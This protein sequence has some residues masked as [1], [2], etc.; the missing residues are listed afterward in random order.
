MAT[1]CTRDH[2]QTLTRPIAPTQPNA[3][4]Y[5]LQNRSIVSFFL[6]VSF[7]LL[8]LFILFCF[9]CNFSSLRFSFCAKPNRQIRSVRFPLGDGRSV[10]WGHFRTIDR[11]YLIQNSLIFILI[12]GNGHDPIRIEST[13]HAHTIPSTFRLRFCDSHRS[14]R[15]W[16]S[17]FLT[18]ADSCLCWY[19]FSYSFRSPFIYVTFICCAAAASCCVIK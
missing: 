15:R 13:T 12:H 11:G 3:Y 6:F 8:F 19:S 16:S 17:S 18:V 5:T 14:R 10:R 7:L 4:V 9:C 1:A 2:R